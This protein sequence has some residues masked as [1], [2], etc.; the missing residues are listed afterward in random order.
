MHAFVQYIFLYIFIYNYINKSLYIFKSSSSLS[1][2][3]IQ[4]F[5]EVSGCTYTRA[6][7]KKYL[8]GLTLNS[9]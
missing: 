9:C 6:G 1:F 5:V 3:P 8:K 7:E 4:Y 2:L